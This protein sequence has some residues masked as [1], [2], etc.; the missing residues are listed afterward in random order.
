VGGSGVHKGN[1]LLFVNGNIY[2]F[3]VDWVSLNTV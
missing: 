3:K 1:H 2:T